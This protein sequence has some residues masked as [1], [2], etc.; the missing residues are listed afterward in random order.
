MR[1][2]LPRTGLLT[3]GSVRFRCDLSSRPRCHRA[4]NDGEIG[5]V[6]TDIIRHLADK[7]FVAERKTN[8]HNIASIHRYR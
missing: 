4:V 8:V 3:T 1:A 2:C 6:L 5:L 7:F